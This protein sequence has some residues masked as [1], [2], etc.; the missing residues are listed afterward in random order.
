MSAPGEI[1]LSID[2]RPNAPVPLRV[3]PE[4]IAARWETHV[5]D[6]FVCT[7]LRIA[8]GREFQVRETQAEI[9]ALI[10]DLQEINT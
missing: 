2:S 10:A 4:Y 6:L 1:Q 3:R 5:G 9:D 7:N 8:G